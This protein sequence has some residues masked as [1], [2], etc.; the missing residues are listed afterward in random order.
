MYE[1]E[2]LQLWQLLAK[3]GE[4]SPHTLR[5]WIANTTPAVMLPDALPVLS[6]A[7]WAERRVAVLDELYRRKFS[8]HVPLG[9]RP[10]EN[11]GVYPFPAQTLVPQA[12]PGTP[13][14][15]YTTV[16]ADANYEEDVDVSALREGLPPSVVKLYFP[17][18]PSPLPEPFPTSDRAALE[19]KEHALARLEPLLEHDVKDKVKASIVRIRWVQPYN[20]SHRPLTIEQL[21]YALTVTAEVPL[22]E[23]RA[24]QVQ[25]SVYKMYA[26][27]DKSV[28]LHPDDYRRWTKRVSYNKSEPIVLMYY[29]E[30]SDSERR[31]LPAI[32]LGVTANKLHF[33]LHSD[34]SL[35]FSSKD[36]VRYAKLLLAHLQTLMPTLYMDTDAWEW[37]ESTFEIAADRSAGSR[38]PPSR[39]A[40][41]WNCLAPYV[42][43][44]P[45]SEGGVETQVVLYKRI[46]DFDA[47]SSEDQFIY[48]QLQA[49]S[50]PERILELYMREN[51]VSPQERDRIAAR[52]GELSED[53]EKAFPRAVR[54]SLPEPHRLLI[55]DMR[56]KALVDTILSFGFSLMS[57]LYPNLQTEEQSRLLEVM[58]PKPVQVIHGI[59]HEDDLHEDADAFDLL[60]S[61][62]GEEEKPPAAEKNAAPVAAPPLQA[63][64]V[65]SQSMHGYFLERMERRGQKTVQRYSKVCPRQRQPVAFTDD[66]W[67]ALVTDPEKGKYA[68][69][70]KEF[71]LKDATSGNTFVCPAFFCTRDELPLSEEDL[72]LVDGE[73]V[74][75]RCKGR[76]IPD[77]S[78]DVIKR[79]DLSVYTVL[80]RSSAAKW[81][82]V[83]AGFAKMGVD[84]P[85]CYTAYKSPD[86]APRKLTNDHVEYILSEDKFP[87]DQN[88]RRFGVLPKAV[89]EWLGIN[90]SDI[91]QDSAIRTMKPGTKALLRMSMP[92]PVV[93]STL[94]SIVGSQPKMLEGEA[95]LRVFMSLNNGNLIRLYGSTWKEDHTQRAAFEAWAAK[96]KIESNHKEWFKVWTGFHNYKSRMW[97]PDTPISHVW[98]LVQREG[99]VRI[100]VIHMD[101][102][103]H[104]GLRCPPL[105]VE[106]FDADSDLLMF[107]EQGCRFE[108]IVWAARAKSAVDFKLVISQAILRD[109]DLEIT[110]PRNVF[111]G[112]RP[113]EASTA[114]YARP[115]RLQAQSEKILEEDTLLLDPYSRVMGVQRASGE[116]LPLYPSNLPDTASNMIQYGYHRLPTASDEY[117]FLSTWG[118]DYAAPMTWIVQSS[119]RPQRIVAIE[120]RG[121]LQVPVVP[122]PYPNAALP[123]LK[124][125]Y[126]YSYDVQQDSHLAYPDAGKD[127]A[128]LQRLSREDQIRDWV[129]YDLSTFLQSAAGA[130]LREMVVSARKPTASVE[131]EVANWIRRTMADDQVKAAV[132]QVPKLKASCGDL[133]KKSCSGVCVVDRG[134]CKTSLSGTPLTYGNMKDW[135][136]YALFTDTKKRERILEGTYPRVTSTLYWERDNEVVFGEG[137]PYP[138]YA[139]KKCVKRD[140]FD[141]AVQDVELPFCD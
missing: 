97:H 139:G 50:S 110:L 105:G 17:A 71:L 40:G 68:E 134:T 22:L 92:E 135:I 35:T 14:Y 119:T 8:E 111:E 74:C 141:A 132:G 49:G 9:L 101:A 98:D 131:A 7:V 30:P 76:V 48:E 95:G 85:C 84:I 106:E 31:S 18:S 69:T 129:L 46:S 56:S 23:Y 32:R 27:E 11:K 57:L 59:K 16:W 127:L 79:L 137:D 37:A 54:I 77:E 90:T 62:F 33:T 28:T 42:T 52:I 126:V 64:A 65:N 53:H 66:E 96:K 86:R 136:L 67:S 109:N 104:V 122:V 89:E 102:E 38:L 138:N 118:S 15:H 36:M 44:M 123:S 73:R 34:T 13:V 88:T 72:V 107:Y 81:P 3:D 140:L 45:V 26:P 55:K 103:G 2:W 20:A 115:L 6:Q 21:F 130:A 93:M 82:R 114:S 94:K 43:A 91:F 108:P 113:F 61:F 125:R 5:A 41:L 63:A 25:P 78:A 58:C 19:E 120:T 80:E 51:P 12:N 116:I 24:S 128:S 29:K 10:E 83:F 117:A 87:M 70:R 47:R 100:V 99:H 1:T 133:D 121:L 4:V 112:C 60:G 39:V 75:P 124:V